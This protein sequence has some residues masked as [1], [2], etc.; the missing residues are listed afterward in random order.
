MSFKVKVKDIKNFL[1]KEN[2]IWNG[3][4]EVSMENGADVEYY[5]N[6]K[7]LYE[8]M[9]DKD[10]SYL[11]KDLFELLCDDNK[12]DNNDNISLSIC[13][14][15]I[16]RNEISWQDIYITTDTFYLDDKDLSAKWKIFLKESKV[17]NSKI[18][19]ENEMIL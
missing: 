11:N 10:F 3:L 18:D 15:D 16:N 4:A 5:V 9:S 1:K 7:N 14:K 2:Y 12:S 8:K 13:L 6:D 19:E 17:N